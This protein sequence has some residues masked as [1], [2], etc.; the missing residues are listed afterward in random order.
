MVRGSFTTL[1]RVFKLVCLALFAY[2]VE[3]AVVKVP[4]GQVGLNTV[5]P[6]VQLNEDYVSL[7][8]A[9]LGTTISPYL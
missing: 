1:A 5:L 2:L 8:V 7:L 6:H 4:W 9:V 3:L